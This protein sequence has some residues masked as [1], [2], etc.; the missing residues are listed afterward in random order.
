MA[1]SVWVFILIT[2][3]RIV[4]QGMELDRT[5]KCL[6]EVRSVCPSEQLLD[7]IQGNLG[8]R[9]D[10]IE[11]GVWYDGKAEYPVR[12]VFTKGNTVYSLSARTCAGNF[13]SLDG[14]ISERL[15]FAGW[16]FY[17]AGWGKVY[18]ITHDNRLV[19]LTNASGTIY[20]GISNIEHDSNDLIVSFFGRRKAQRLRIGRGELLKRINELN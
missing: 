9:C 17:R 19:P 1:K 16:Q 4:T 18:L 5:E 12:W 8:F 14:D 20:S 6:E 10:R 3:F 7:S 11:A 2:G 13:E 15:S